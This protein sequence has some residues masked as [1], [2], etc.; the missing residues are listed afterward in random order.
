M[1][2][3]DDFLREIRAEVGIKE[4]IGRSVKLQKSGREYKGCCPFHNEKTPSFTVFSDKFHCFGCGA[5][6]DVIDFAKMVHGGTFLDAVAIIAQDAGRS[7]PNWHAGYI[8]GPVVE[9][10]PAP[11]VAREPD[12]IWEPGP[13][14]DPEPK[15]PRGS[16]DAVY[17]YVDKDG[18]TLGYVTR[19][20]HIDK[21]T[22]KRRKAILP[23]TWGHRVWEGRG[24]HHDAT[25][26]HRKHM[27]RPLPL[28][29]L[30]LL[31][32]RPAAPVLVVE[33]E[34][35]CDAAR[36]LFPAY[37]CVTWPRGTAN[38]QYV[39]WSPL[40]GRDV[41]IWPDN[42]PP[43]PA[44][45]PHA[46]HRPGQEA[47][48][49]I[50]D[51]L[52]AM[53]ALPTMLDISSL[54]EKFGAADLV[55][56]NP[57]GW[58]ATR[59]PRIAAPPEFDPVPESAYDDMDDSPP[60]LRAIG[61][62]IERFNKKYALVNEDGKVVIFQF[63]F[64]DLMKRKRIDRL[65]TQDFN[66]LY[67][68]EKILVH[69]HPKDPEKDKYSTTSRVWLTNKN[70]R[71]Y[72]NGVRFDPT[73]QT[74]RD[75]ILNLWEGFSITPAPGDWSLMK[76]HIRDIICQGDAVRYDFLMGWMARM[77]QFPAEQGEVAIVMKGGEGTGKGTLA[78]AIIKIIGQHSLAISNGKHLVSNFNS[79][80]R[81]AIFLF[82]DEA[83]FAGDKAHVGVL[84]SIITEPHLTVEAKFQN[85]TQTP[86]F[87]HIMMASNEEWVVPASL[88]ARRFLV[89]E[90]PNLVQKNYTYFS[91]IGRQMEAGGYQAMLHDLLA[92]DISNFNFRDAP[93]TEGLTNQQKLSLGVPEQWW[94]DC[95]ERGYIFRS[96]LGLEADFSVWFNEATT[97]LLYA[98]YI[99]FSN[100]KRERNAMSREALGKFMTHMG[101]TSKRLRGRAVGEH[102]TEEITNGFGDTRRVAKMLRT[103]RAYGYSLGSL[104]Y[105]RDTFCEVLNMPMVWNSG[106]FDE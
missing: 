78:K 27:A 21:D 49:W 31:A 73:S 64:D 50:Y 40:A 93:H 81:D 37:A 4:Y 94:K 12:E 11:V 51:T 57:T 18:R 70:R 30:D 38:V 33:G 41:I 14:P 46:G 98:S 5:H 54:P 28:Y 63:G 55:D 15:L 36:G 83:F 58:L 80:L 77:L 59:I 10:P 92:Y 68:N 62:V 91:E 2:I 7:M 22:G 72:I 39:D 67:M 34:K 23:Y 100:A 90:V 24:G 1:A 25:G 105:A 47:A 42:D 29:G 89:L 8:P 103:E 104:D 56:N 48:Q 102:I 26:W 87:L 75:G 6:G 13:A 95:L 9:R 85:A 60:H 3:P 61:K 96:R 45:H 20:N 35:D 97:E 16:W 53:G 32:Q 79:H 44:D 84:K 82:A 74:P 43:F 69:P 17:H 65:S 106:G 19:K 76:S 88:D 86:N 52:G 101:A 99:E 66:T 71:Q